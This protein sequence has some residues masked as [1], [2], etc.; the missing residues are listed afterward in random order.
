[1]GSKQ[2]GQVKG[3]RNPYPQRIVE[4][5][6]GARV[7][8]LHQGQSVVDEIVYMAEVGNDLAGEVL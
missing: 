8:A 3:G 4:L 5:L 6:I 2:L 7:D 1:M